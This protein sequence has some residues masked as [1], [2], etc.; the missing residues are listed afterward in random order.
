MMNVS[1]KDVAALIGYKEMELMILR[2]Q[3]A[4]ALARVA[5]LEKKANTQP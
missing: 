2:Q 4:E 1:E 5:E 3:L